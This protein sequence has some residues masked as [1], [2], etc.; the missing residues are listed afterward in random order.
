MFDIASSE[1]L[2]VAIVALVVLG[3]KELP[4]LLR[5]IGRWTAK[6]RDIRDHLKG[7][8]DE[9]MQHAEME[10]ADKAFREA[11]E[12]LRRSEDLLAARKAETTPTTTPA[13]IPAPTITPP[14]EAATPAP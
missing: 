6:M 11:K 4:A 13:A 5:Q 8:F 3:P 2:L 1:L 9:M 10:E 14:A 12:A 7:G